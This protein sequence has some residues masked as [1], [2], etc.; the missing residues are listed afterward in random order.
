MKGRPF[1]ISYA[2]AILE[3]ICFPQGQIIIDANNLF[4]SLAPQ[5]PKAGEVKCGDLTDCSSQ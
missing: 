1:V 4:L 5:H 2:Y 3:M